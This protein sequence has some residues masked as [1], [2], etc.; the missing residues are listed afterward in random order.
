MQKILKILFYYIQVEGKIVVF[1][2]EWT[3]YG[4]T[5]QYRT[6]GASE[7]SKKGAVAS[8]IRSIAPFSIGSPHTGAQSYAK[9][10]KPIP[11][12]CIT[13]EDAH[14]IL[15]LYRNGK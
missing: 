15:R 10:I 6:R 11:T 1:V 14:M 7:A 5:V 12:A 2:P 4:S 9:D 3:G 8:L 13:I